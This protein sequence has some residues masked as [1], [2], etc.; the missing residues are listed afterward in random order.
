M[1]ITSRLHNLT[2]RRYDRALA[3]DN[4]I[5]NFG[6][7]L[8]FENQ[9]DFSSLAEKE[10]WAKYV[11]DSMAEVPKRSTEISFE[12]GKKI[13]NHLAEHLKDYRL[14]AEFRFQGSIINN[15]HI[16]GYSDI[17]LLVI[18][19]KY[20]SLEKPQIPKSPYNGNP[21]DDLNEL[22]NVCT[23]I[24]R[25][26]YSVAKIDTSGAKSI[27]ISGGSLRR[28]IDIV[29]A[30][31]FDSNLYH[32][33]PQYDYLRG[34]QV[35]NKEKNSRDTNYPFYNK[36]LLNRKDARTGSLY[37]SVVRLAKN[38][39][40]DSDNKIVQDISSYDIQA[41]FYHM[42][43]PYFAN[44]QG[45]DVVPVITKYLKQLIEKPS[46][47]MKLPVPDKTRLI[48]DKVSL[49]EL[50]LLYDEFNEINSKLDHATLHT[51]SSTMN[52]IIMEQ[53]A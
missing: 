2:S 51:I 1:D 36:E 41:I 20:Y 29:P 14:S 42:N 19:D 45:I 39:R 35:Y 46:V 12:E 17:D 37:K 25:D 7:S 33:Y 18:T 44:I 10:K 47:Y 24:L 52:N 31:W 53:G 50:I 16:K 4:S 34:I 13:K 40:C 15:T 11:L 48:S 26:A 43:D 5:E 28:D 32:Q 49:H 38:V 30:N 22:R 9:H 21:L 3:T 23:E 6:K 8:L 27:T